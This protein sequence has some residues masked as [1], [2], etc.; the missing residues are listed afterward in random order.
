VQ[1]A[2]DEGGQQAKI[3]IEQVLGAALGSNRPTH[4]L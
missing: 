2:A 1:F 3:K 4:T